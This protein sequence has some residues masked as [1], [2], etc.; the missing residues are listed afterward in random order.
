M[1]LVYCFGHVSTGRILR[2]RDRFPLA[3]GYAEVQEEFENHS[4]EATGTALAL[5][6]LGVDVTLEGN[7]IGDNQACRRTLDFLRQKGIDVSGLRVQSGYAGV[8]ET[9]ISDGKSR[10]VFGRYCDLLFTEPQWDMPRVESIRV[11]KVAC[12]DPAFGSATALV[13]DASY[14]FGIPLVSC[15]ARYDSELCARSTGALVISNEFLRR[16]YPNAVGMGPERHALLQEYLRRCP[17]LVVFTSGHE[18]ILYG[19]GKG[20]LSM[21]ICESEP[22]VVD[23]VDSAGAGDS[24]RGGLIDALL[25]RKLEDSQAIEFASAVAACVCTT[26]PGCVHAP[27]RDQVCE[28]LHTKE[29]V[30]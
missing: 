19:R 20:Q 1:A 11:A 22:F 5:K 18:S 3:D 29:A 7:W 9:V 6:A 15:D 14:R 28:L 23:V 10:T 25:L 2:L 13:A 12:V 8:Q 4:G 26:I 16:E 24:F 30:R 27:N 21:Q 17:G